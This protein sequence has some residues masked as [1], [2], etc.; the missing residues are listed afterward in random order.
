MKYEIQ[1]HRKEN[2]NQVLF[3]LVLKNPY[4]FFRAVC[5]QFIIHFAIKVQ[6]LLKMIINIQ[7]IKNLKGLKR[8]FKPLSYYIIRIFL[9]I[10]VILNLPVYTQEN[11]ET[12]KTR[13]G[14]GVGYDPQFLSIQRERPY[15]W[16]K[17]VGKIYLPIQFT[18]WRLEPEVGFWRESYFDDTSTEPSK[19]ET[20]VFQGG[21]GTFYSMRKN[22]SILYFGARFGGVVAR[23]TE[24]SVLNREI[25][26]Y[27]KTGGYLGP[28][29]G[30]EHFLTE[31]ISLGVE[32][33]ILYTRLPALGEKYT[34]L[35]YGSTR[36]VLF[37]RWYY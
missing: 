28:V 19:Y 6:I 24:Y 3:I 34:E 14:F 16:E 8:M 23:T 18:S 17:P 21:I 29:V 22:S 2:I 20:G 30:V 1:S 35:D 31:H 10:L 33:Q 27:T 11:K 25:D 37:V 13:W 5:S 7:T 15:D 9:C 32:G 4:G 36:G 26:T 12:G